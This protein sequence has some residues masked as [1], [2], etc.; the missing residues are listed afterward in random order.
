MVFPR[1]EGNV[2]TGNGTGI[3]CNFS[4]YMQVHGNNLHDNRNFGLV[5]GDNMSILMQNK[6]PY[7]YLGRFSFDASPTDADK[8]PHQSR[9][10]DPF[11]ENA[12]VVD[13]R[14]NWWG[15]S[16]TAE[17]EKVGENGNISVIED[18]FDKPDTFYQEEV[19]RRDRAA[20]APWEKEPLK[21]VGPPP[22]EYSGIVGKVIFNGN[23]V[24]GV[25]VHAYN[26]GEGGFRGEGQAYSSPTDA[27]GS[28]S[29]NIPAGTYFLVA[30]GP[31]PPYPFSEPGSGALFG[32]FEGNPVTVGSLAKETSIV[33]VVRRAATVVTTGWDP[34]RAGIKGVVL[35][36]SGPVA[37][38]S[39]HIYQDAE[40]KFRGPDHFAPQG[41]VG[42]G[43]D[44]RGAFSIELPPGSYYIVA[45]KRKGGDPLVPPQ[46]GDLYGYYDGNPLAAEP[47]T[48]TAI[49]IQMTGMGDPAPKDR[50]STTSAP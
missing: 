13:A 43:T 27:D 35:G 25:R 6:I 23:P 41:A 16:A 48:K 18:F 38:A 32:Y 40:Q 24:A 8:V 29:L 28:F 26:D 37:G 19:Y 14:A 22:R 47:G 44:E 17:M 10:L 12:G 15:A 39:I 50:R 11:P 45:S 36:P 3:Y 2:I 7:R 30:K 34:G 9:K 4:A 1:I 5:V 46:P 31:T 42:G 33:Q 49:T 20:Y 21:Q